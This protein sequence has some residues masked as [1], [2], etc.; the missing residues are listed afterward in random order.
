MK[1][2]NLLII[3]S[4]TLISLVLIAAVPMEQSELVAITITNKSNDYATLKLTGPAFYYLMVKPNT[5]TTYT[6]LRGDYTQKFYSC[7]T[8]VDPNLDLT[9]KQS[10]YVPPCG[11][12]AFAVDK[13]A[14]NKVDAGQ[15]I[16]LV[17]VNFENTTKYNLVLVL[18]GPSQYVFFIRSGEEVSYTISKGDYQ[19]TQWGCPTVKNFNYYPFAHKETDLTCPTW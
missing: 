5:T 12:K 10:I 4:V 19:V 3:L 15:L 16:R 1:N 17:K 8:F 18:R 2:R 11:E 9:K 7:G 14:S 6:I 13:S